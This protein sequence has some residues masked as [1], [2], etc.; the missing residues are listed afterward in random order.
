MAFACLA[1]AKVRLVGTKSKTRLVVF[2]EVVSRLPWNDMQIVETIY[3]T[4]HTFEIVEDSAGV[5][6]STRYYVHKDGVRTQGSYP[7][8][9]TAVAAAK[10]QA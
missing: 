9:A 1:A 8:I 5:P 4:R 2:G 7:T 6:G 10:E 3:S